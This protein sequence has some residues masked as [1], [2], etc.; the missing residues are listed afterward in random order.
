MKYAVTGG[1]VNCTVVVNP[2]VGSERRIASHAIG[3]VMVSSSVSATDSRRLDHQV[4]AGIPELDSGTG[5]DS[6]PESCK[7]LAQFVGVPI[8]VGGVLL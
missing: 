2:V 3:A 6:A 4:V 8:V 1:D 5:V 7:S